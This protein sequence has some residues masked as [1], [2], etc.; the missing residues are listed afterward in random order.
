[1]NLHLGCGKRYLPGWHHRD[2]S[3]YPHVDKVGPV[4]DLSDIR[5]ETVDNIYASHVLEYFDRFEAKAVLNEW[6]RV[7]KPGGSLRLA[8]PDFQ[9]LVGVYHDSDDIVS[10]L[11]P[12]FGRMST[13]SENIYH[14]TV[15]DFRSLTAAL[16]EAGFAE[17]EQYSPKTF[18]TEIAGPEY[19]DHSLAFWPHMDFNGT[20]ISLCLVSKKSHG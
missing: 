7:L 14:R 1:M 16:E 10:I 17:V 2:I 9:S 12:L 4:E 5:K 6:F 8:V 19:D 11:G 15:W 18:L 13:G 3:S 20:Q